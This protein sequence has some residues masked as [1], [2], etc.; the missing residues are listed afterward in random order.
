MQ[1]ITLPRAS[2]A[3][4]TEDQLQR[5]VRCQTCYGKTKGPTTH[6]YTGGATLEDATCWC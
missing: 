5:Y 4:Y 2:V 6:A 1:V 3:K